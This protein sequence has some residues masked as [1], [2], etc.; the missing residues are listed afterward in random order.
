MSRPNETSR[1]CCCRMTLLT[2]KVS[3]YFFLMDGVLYFN[4]RV[5]V[6]NLINCTLQTMLPKHARESGPSWDVHL[7]H[8]LFAYL[9]RP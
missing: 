9:V 5:V 2:K 7:Q 3:P 8:L 6:S 1:K 4:L